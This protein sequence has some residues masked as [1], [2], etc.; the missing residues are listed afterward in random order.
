[1]ER[2]STCASTQWI[3][4][5]LTSGTSSARDDEDLA[6][7]GLADIKESKISGHADTAEWPEEV[8]KLAAFRWSNEQFIS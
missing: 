5:I 3:R 6:S 4:K 2:F 8:D 1:L 7:L